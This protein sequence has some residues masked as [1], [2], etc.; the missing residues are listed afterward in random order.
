MSKVLFVAIVAGVVLL[1]VGARLQIDECFS[2][3]YIPEIGHGQTADGT[4]YLINN[5][6]VV[7]LQPH[8]SYAPP[9]PKD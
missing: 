9:R 5:G 1:V 7:Y 8:A 3:G 6:K 2:A 4:A